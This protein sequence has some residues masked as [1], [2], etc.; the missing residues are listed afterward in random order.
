MKKYVEQD[1][2]INLEKILQGKHVVIPYVGTSDITTDQ[3]H[4]EIKHWN[5]W[6]SVISQLY[7]YNKALPR[8][9][10][11]AYFFGRQPT[12][13]RLNVILEYIHSISETKVYHVDIDNQ[14]VS[15]TDMFDN[16]NVVKYDVCE[17]ENICYLLQDSYKK[18][19]LEA[20]SKGSWKD[21]AIDLDKVCKW[22]NISKFN[23]LRTLRSS[24][25][26][27][28][29]YTIT[30]SVN[31]KGKYGG[32]N[33]KLVMIT[34]DCFKRL[35]MKSTSNKADEVRTYFIELEQCCLKQSLMP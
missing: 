34:P 23:I 5:S 28:I 12:G 26:E 11:R 31:K 17:R 18:E 32:N 10:L 3:F 2:Q 33:Y 24:Y 4:A 29:D 13:K 1:Y 20:L 21:Y 19:I 22:L 6:K 25:R 27:D 15:I 16:S 30:K 7:C 9:E 35:S 14:C 8:N